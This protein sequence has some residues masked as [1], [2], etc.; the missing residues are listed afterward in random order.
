MTTLPSES[1]CTPLS[2]LRKSYA[3]QVA[4]R[5]RAQLRSPFHRTVETA[6]AQDCT[7]GQMAH[8]Q[9]SGFVRRTE[10]RVLN[11]EYVNASGA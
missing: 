7:L 11:I 4:E 10:R 9:G 3:L 5:V 1:D 8:A 2:K 6:I